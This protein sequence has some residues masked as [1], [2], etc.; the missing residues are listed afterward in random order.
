MINCLVGSIEFERDFDVNEMFS[1][2]GACDKI[3]VV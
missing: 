1:L 3:A 2:C